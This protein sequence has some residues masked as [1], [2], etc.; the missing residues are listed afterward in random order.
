MGLCTSIFFLS[1]I[2]EPKIVARSKAIWNK[3]LLGEDSKTPHGAI[4]DDS[5]GALNT[6]SDLEGE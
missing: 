1:V 6:D 5:N 3:H 4:D 2:N